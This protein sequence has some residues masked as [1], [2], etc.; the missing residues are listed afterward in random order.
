MEI[1]HR[2]PN[3]LVFVEVIS[4]F[5][6]SEICGQIYISRVVHKNLKEIHIYEKLASPSRYQ[7]PILF[8][9]TLR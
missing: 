5:Q 8:L 9:D 3:Y 4:K 1:Y 6:F 7:Y 2:F